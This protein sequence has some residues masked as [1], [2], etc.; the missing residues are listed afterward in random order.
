M[1]QQKSRCLGAAW[2]QKICPFER[3]WSNIPIHKRIKYDKNVRELSWSKR[4]E[5]AHKV[6]KPEL[7]PRKILLC[8]WWDR[9]FV[10]SS[11]LRAKSQ[12]GFLPSTTGTLESTRNSQYFQRK[13]RGIPPGQRQHA[14]PHVFDG[15]ETPRARVGSFKKHPPYILNLASTD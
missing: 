11:F 13:T 15:L 5:A 9:K 12:F 6:I 7:T 2:V 4:N 10:T 3:F 1:L 14:R 8:I